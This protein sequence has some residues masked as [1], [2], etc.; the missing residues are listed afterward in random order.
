[1]SCFSS[2]ILSDCHVVVLLSITYKFTFPLVLFPSPLWAIF[3]HL[4]L[5]LNIQLYGF[6]NSLS[7]CVYSNFVSFLVSHFLGLT[8]I[9]LKTV[10]FS[11][12]TT[13]LWRVKG[14]V[15][16]GIGLKQTL[17]STLPN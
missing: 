11:C 13:F 6:L 14:Y 5:W 3:I 2:R 17:Q 7:I 8:I 15:A 12:L 10:V 4:L 9:L 16:Y 1:M